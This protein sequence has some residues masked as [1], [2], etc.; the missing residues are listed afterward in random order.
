MFNLKALQK[1]KTVKYGVPMLV[2]IFYFT[3]KYVIQ[4]F[5]RLLAYIAYVKQV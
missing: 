1:N 3:F 2:S 5:V 4:R